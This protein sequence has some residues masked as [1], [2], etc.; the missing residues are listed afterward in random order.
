MNRLRTVWARVRAWRRIRF[1]AAGLL[2][3]LGTLAVGFAAINTGNNLL[4]LLLGAMLGAMGVSGWLS[5]R[6]I[7]DLSITRSV[8]RGTPVGQVARIRYRV[9]NHKRR[10]ASLA[11]ELAE[12]GLPGVAFVGRVDA[13]GELSAHATNTFERRGVHVLSTLTVSTTFPFGLFR[14][15]RDLTLPGEIVVWPRADLRVRPPREGAGRRRA[16]AEAQVGAAAGARGE[17]RGLREYRPGDDPRDIHWRSSARLSGPVVREYDR[18]ASETL[19][20]CLDT[21]TSPGEAAED[22]ADIAGSLAGAAARD[23]RP[24]ALVAGRGLI[25]P[26]LGPAHLEAVLDALARV[27]FE[28]G[29]PAPEPPIHPSACVLVTAGAVRGADWADVYGAGEAP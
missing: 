22:A 10:M 27:D 26:G 24:F 12:E 19:W 23:G 16:R 11:V 25:A 9:T 21:G 7:R 5:E 18:D 20:I 15:E 1:T 2:F 14:R 8:P 13:G 6:M 4:H 28:P 17:Y 3:T 29:A